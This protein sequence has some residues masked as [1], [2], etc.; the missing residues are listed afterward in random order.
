[1]KVLVKGGSGFI[2]RNVTEHV[3]SGQEVVRVHF[4]V[5]IVDTRAIVPRHA[6]PRVPA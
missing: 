3:G 2:G 5:I 6:L 4:F 1:M